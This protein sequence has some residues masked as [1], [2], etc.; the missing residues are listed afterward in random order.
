M[1]ILEE[2]YVRRFYSFCMIQ[3]SDELR[4]SLSNSAV[5]VC[6]LL[7]YELRAPAT[8]VLGPGGA[9]LFARLQ[10]G[11]PPIDLVDAT[12]GHIDPDNGL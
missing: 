8:L 9:F 5:A 2:G 12:A 3:S 1:T 6:A 10:H 11:R 4:L 7:H